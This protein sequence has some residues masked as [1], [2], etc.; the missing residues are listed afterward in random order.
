MKKITS[1]FE[2]AIDLFIISANVAEKIR[3][4]KILKINDKCSTASE[5][6]AAFSPLIKVA[7]PNGSANTT[8]ILPMFQS[9]GG[10]IK[11]DYLKLES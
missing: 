7:P 10:R 11:V 5:I 4:Q 8:S 2:G 3:I 9:M 1:K 6:L